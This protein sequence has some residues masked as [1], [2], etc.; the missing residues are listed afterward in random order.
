MKVFN[1]LRNLGAHVP[2][3]S[4]DQLRHKLVHDYLLRLEKYDSIIN[5]Y[6]RPEWLEKKSINAPYLYEG[7]SRGWLYEVS[8]GESPSRVLQLR[9]EPD[10]TPR[11]KKAK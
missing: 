6:V 5:V 2:S 11:K 3:D 9:S 7:P 4:N 8:R 1:S 10:F